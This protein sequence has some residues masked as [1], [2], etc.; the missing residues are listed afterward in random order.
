MLIRVVALIL[1][2]VIGLSVIVPGTVSYASDASAGDSEDI[3]KLARYSEILNTFRDRY[4]FSDFLRDYAGT[5]R[6]DAEYL[7]DAGDY[8]IAEN[9]ETRKLEDWEGISGTSIWTDETGLVEWEVYVEQAGLYNISILFYSYEGKKSDIQRSVFINGRQPFFEANTVEF[10][11]T[12]VNELPEI[13]QDSK[14]NDLRPLQTE[15]HTWQEVPLRDPLGIY[16][17]PFV[18]YLEEGRN[19]IGFIS[20]REPM[21]IRSLKIHQIAEI[22]PYAFFAQSFASLPRPLTETIHI[23]GQ[24][25]N[26]KSSPMLAPQADNSGPGITPY[27]PKHVRINYI[28][29]Y[30]WSAPGSWIE[31]DVD[32][33][34]AGLYQIALNVRQHFS[35][36]A[37]TYRRI[38]INGEVPFSEM[39]AVPFGFDSNWRIEVLGEDEPYLFRLE[40]GVN[41]I[42][43]EAVLGDYSALYQEVQDAVLRLNGMY[44]EIIMVTGLSP[45][46]FRDYRIGQRLPHL[47]DELIAEKERMDLLYIRLGEL[48]GGLSERDAVIQNASAMLATLSSNIENIPQRIGELTASIGALGNW[49]MQVREQRLSIGDIYIVA[50][51]AEAPK[52]ESGFLMFLRRLWYGI[53]SLFYS[54]F[55]DVNTIGDSA[56]SANADKITVWVGSGRDQANVIRTMIDEGFTGDTGIYVDLK[57]VDVSTNILLP[58]VLSGQGP[59]VAL[60]LGQDIPMNYGMRGAAADLSVFPDFDEVAG[61]FS[62]ASMTPFSYGGQVFGLPE[63]ITFQM[64]F[65]RKDVL[66]ELGLDVPDT[67]DDVIASMSVL[68]QNH[69]E[70]G[71]PLESGAIGA[72]SATNMIDVTFGMFLF[73]NGGEFYNEDGSLSALDSD[74]S[75][76]VFRDFTRFYTDYGMPSVYDFA[77]R[78]RTGDMPMAIAD[79]TNYNML[80]VLAPEISGLWGFRPVPGTVLADGSIDRTVAAGGSAA[81]MMDTTDN[82]SAA[83]EFLKWWTSAD[84]QL[85]YGRAME[86]LMGESARH[87]TANLEAF[88][89]MPW[90]VEEYQSLLTQFEYVRGIPQVPG[91]YFTSRQLRNA[92]YSATEAREVGPREALREFVSYI[93]D[94]IQIKRIEFGLD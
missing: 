45:D 33:P 19:T 92:F 10:L 44:R 76:K 54:F 43:I 20:L 6:P 79:Y 70:F 42:R 30:S 13:Q 8:I 38:L 89:Q 66:F 65:Y 94:E 31:W 57:L 86:S 37:N 53:Q 26:R 28:G 1:V 63:T 24:D 11:R 59:D 84:V 47:Y 15:L 64:L 81:V 82:P 77:N 80:Q 29:G 39:E 61:R 12:W 36:G 9:M 56:A 83:W 74:I 58:S 3:S 7:I 60:T 90:S 25:A 73:Q 68:A 17:E 67:W 50:A 71:L 5:I 85:R 87:P 75:L 21:V 46:S 34:E 48:S 69:M 51:D 52:T 93:N 55:I 72:P 22:K 40:E 49:L 41:T 78:F 14:G 18:F 27:S 4:Y 62:P 91:G 32:I 23:N 35:W 16:D 88:S 2:I